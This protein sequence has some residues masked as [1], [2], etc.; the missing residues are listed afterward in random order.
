M[1]VNIAPGIIHGA[2]MVADPPRSF[3][4]ATRMMLTALSTVSFALS[5]TSAVPFPEKLDHYPPA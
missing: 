1:S 3:S 4:R 5:M 2:E